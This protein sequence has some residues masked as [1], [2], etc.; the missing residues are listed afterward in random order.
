MAE[1]YPDRVEKMVL[2]GSPG[3]GMTITDGLNALRAYKPSPENMPA[4]LLDYSAV[5]KSILTD[6]LVRICYEAGAARILNASW[7]DP[8]WAVLVWLT[9]V[10]GAGEGG[11]VPWARLGH[12]GGCRSTTRVRPVRRAQAPTRAT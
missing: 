11:S 3:V 8:A 1:R 12:G 2:M 4:L 10:T 5:D 7:E 9:M 6:D